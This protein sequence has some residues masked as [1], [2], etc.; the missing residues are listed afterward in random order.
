MSD[1]ELRIRKDLGR[2]L[3]RLRAQSGISQPELAKRVSERIGRPFA[4]SNIGAW[5]LG[6]KI[7]NADVLP[8]IAS[9]LGISLEDLLK[10]RP[11]AKGYVPV[12]DDELPPKRF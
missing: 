5:E 6:A 7:Q 1:D 3:A 11:T 8:A 10:V 4:H 9:A 12:P 2:W